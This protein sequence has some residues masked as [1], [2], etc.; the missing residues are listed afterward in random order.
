MPTKPSGGFDLIL[1]HL[2]N[3]YWFNAASPRHNSLE[4]CSKCHASVTIHNLEKIVLAFGKMTIKTCTV[5]TC[6]RCLHEELIEH[7]EAP[8][9]PATKR[10]LTK[11]FAKLPKSIQQNILL[12]V[13]S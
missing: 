7:R 12:N 4:E 10:N 1:G 9:K 8:K 6:P 3:D 2:Y 11:L 5:Y 13:R